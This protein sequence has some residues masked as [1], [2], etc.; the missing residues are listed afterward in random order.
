MAS[1]QFLKK[2]IMFTTIRA[3]IVAF[4]PQKAKNK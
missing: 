4:Q 2:L 3:T 1:K